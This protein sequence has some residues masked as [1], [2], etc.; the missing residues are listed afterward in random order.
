M[1]SELQIRVIPAIAD[2]SAAQWDA[3]ANP[4]SVS[5]LYPYNPFVSHAFLSALEVSGSAAAR[6]P[7][8]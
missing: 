4:Q 3:C 7:D 5:E 6:D 8:P 2:I 1:T